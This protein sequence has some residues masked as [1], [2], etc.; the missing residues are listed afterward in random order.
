[1]IQSFTVT[2]HLGDRLM[3]DMGR[4]EQSGFLV[5]SVSGLGPPKAEINL[6]AF[7]T[8]DGALFNSARL[9]QRN[10]VFN[11]T[12]V[13]TSEEDI[14]DVRKK[15]YKFFPSKKEL[16]IVIKTDRR[17]VETVGYVESNE[18]EIF[19]SLE[20]TQI[21][22]LCPDPYFY[23]EGPP[24][25]TTFYGITPWFEFPFSNE[26][27]SDKLL[28]FDNI[29]D[30][31]ERNIFYSGDA[32]TGV[33]VRM[34]I[35]GDVVNPTIY[36]FQTLEHIKLNTH[37]LFG[38]F[39]PLPSDSGLIAG[40]EVIIDSTRGN[41]RIVLLRD[42]VETNILNG[43]ERGSSWLTLISGDNVFAFDAEE[44]GSNIQ[45]VIEHKTMYEGV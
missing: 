4:P 31:T 33:V 35:V 38:G 19:S 7:S 21:S 40:D 10:I 45:L 24:F 16:G 20:G 44:G 13:E 2:N 22:I 25:I 5:R 29:E 12:F 34:R 37:N 39:S 42:G 18:P 8:N 36:N 23:S 6:G 11:L 41:K 32:E 28:V 26:S 14:E 27:L 15:S 3:I 17:T 9:G 1:M 43:L 30:A